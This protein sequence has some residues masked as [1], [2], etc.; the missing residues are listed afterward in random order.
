MQSSSYYGKKR[1]EVLG[2][3]KWMLGG[4]EGRAVSFLRCCCS[5]CV[6]VITAV[7]G[8]CVWLGL[9][10]L[11]LLSEVATWILRALIFLRLAW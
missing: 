6:V 10:V 7:R 4:R 11:L 8:I 9:C 1:V 5:F 3:G 2:Q